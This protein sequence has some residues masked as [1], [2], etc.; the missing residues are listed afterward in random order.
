[1]HHELVRNPVEQREGWVYAPKGYG[2]GA[3]VI[4]E[5]VHKHTV[6]F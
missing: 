5:T 2:I 4:E 3:D 6:S 1:M